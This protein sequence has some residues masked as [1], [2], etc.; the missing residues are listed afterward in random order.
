MD[1]ANLH[2]RSVVVTSCAI[3]ENWFKAPPVME[4]WAK[5]HKVQVSANT[6]I[7][8]YPKQR[9]RPAVATVRYDVQRDNYTALMETYSTTGPIRSLRF[10]VSNLWF[11]LQQKTRKLPKINE[12]PNIS[13]SV[14]WCDW[15]RSNFDLKTRTASQYHKGPIH[16]DTLSSHKCPISACIGVLRIWSRTAQIKSG[17]D[18]L[19]QS[20]D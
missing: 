9:W 18:T 14:P 13:V 8:K 5:L 11:F 19:H 16:R 7:I 20:E 3:H 10:K 1:L 4:N 12:P 17:S 2:N 6:E 15:I